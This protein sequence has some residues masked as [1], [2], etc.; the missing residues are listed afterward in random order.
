MSKVYIGK[1]DFIKACRNAI[2]NGDKKN[3][4]GLEEAIKIANEIENQ[5]CVDMLDSDKG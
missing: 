5:V 3:V 2:E 1:N 4:A